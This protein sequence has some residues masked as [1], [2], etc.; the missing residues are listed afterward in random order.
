[1]QEG[2]LHCGFLPEACGQAGARPVRAQLR[3]DHRSAAMGADR[4]TLLARTKS[5]VLLISV[6]RAT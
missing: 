5:L 6:F 1:M 3:K 4:S 2:I